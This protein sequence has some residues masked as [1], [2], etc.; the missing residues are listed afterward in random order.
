MLRHTLP[1]NV[2][3]TFYSYFIPSKRTF[4]TPSLPFHHNYPHH[5]TITSHPHHLCISMPFFWSFFCR[6]LT[7]VY[8]H[9][10]RNVHV[11]FMYVLPVKYVLLSFRI[12]TPLYLCMFNRFY[13]FDA[14]IYAFSNQYH[15]TVCVLPHSGT[16]L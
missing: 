4:Y 2:L 9:S 5:V 14:L 10:W 7:P 11:L 15:V 1:E 16:I 13:I 12:T 6:S 8:N 3:H